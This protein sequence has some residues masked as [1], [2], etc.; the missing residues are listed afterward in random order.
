MPRKSTK[1]KNIKLVE[2]NEE[3]PTTATTEETTME[4]NTAPPTTNADTSPNRGEI[5]DVE[6]EDVK[7]IYEFKNRLGDLE[8]YF[9]NMCLHFEKE[10][11]NIITQINYGQNDLYIMAQQ[12]QKTL[13]VDDELTYELKLP[14]ESGQKGFF[15]RKDD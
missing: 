12:L 6:W 13:N 3:V 15:V 1:T 8:Q 11:S 9:A 7:S 2:E 10:K 14:T 5:I 4:A